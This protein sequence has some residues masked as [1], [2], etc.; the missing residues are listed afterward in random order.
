ME[1]SAGQAPLPLS[2]QKNCNNC[3]QTKRRCDRRT[4]VCTRCAEKGIQ[5]VYSKSR[6]KRTGPYDKYHSEPT[7]STE[8]PPFGYSP[9]SLL[10]TNIS[11]E[12]GSEGSLSTDRGLIGASAAGA[13]P[14]DFIGVPVGFGEDIP[15]GSFVDLIGNNNS[16]SPSQ[17]FF[18]TE[19][20]LYLERPGTPVDEETLRGYQEMALF[21][22]SSISFH[23]YKCRDPHYDFLYFSAADDL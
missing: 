8:M 23:C 22:V 5:C 19:D 16:P 11:T 21:C 6:G 17:W 10:D 4:P 1:S 3:V 7:A 12:G 20:S 18:P 14:Q 15:T 9:R 2:R 13:R